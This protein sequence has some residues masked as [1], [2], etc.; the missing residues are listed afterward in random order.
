MAQ[1]VPKRL[2]QIEKRLDSIEKILNTM[3]P[4]ASIIKSQAEIP[5]STTSDIESLLELPDSLR[6][7][8]LA[9]NELGEATADEIPKI[10]GRV[11]SVESIYLNELVRMGRLAKT[12][13]GRKVFFKAVRYY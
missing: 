5:R 7:T 6:K 3:V 12:R 4:K 13:K 11:R 8:M 10:T 9:I 1:E 2:E